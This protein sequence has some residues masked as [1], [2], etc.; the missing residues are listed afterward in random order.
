M[1]LSILFTIDPT[2]V[3]RNDSRVPRYSRVYCNDSRNDSR[4][5]RYS[6]VS[7]NDFRNDSI[8][9]LVILIILEFLIMILKFPLNG[10]T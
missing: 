1:I 4:V 2:N 7:C 9:I 3:K 8:M 5:P 10:K 6:R